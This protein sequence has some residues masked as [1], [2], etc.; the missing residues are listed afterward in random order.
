MVMAKPVGPLCNL[1]CM[2]CY[3]LKTEGS[4]VDHHIRMSDDVLENFIKQYIQTNSGPVVSFTWHGGEPTLAGLDFYRKAVELQKKYLPK[5]WTCWNNLQTNG[6]NLNEEWCAFLAQEHF[7]VGIS[8][9]G[10]QMIH[11]HYR[12]D[13]LGQGSYQRVLDSIHRLKK[14]GILP[15]LLCTVNALTTQD[16]LG[17][18]RTL[19]DLNT[20]WIQ[21]IPILVK[22][23]DGQLS[24][25]SVDPKAYGEF[26]KV[27]FDEWI[28]NDLGV[29]DVQLFAETAMI[30]AGGSASVCW[31]APS[32]G[33]VLVVERNGN[34]YSCDHYVSSEYYL[35]NIETSSLAD[36]VDSK[37]QRQF[38][39]NKADQIAQKCRSCPFLK[40]C[41]GGCPKDRFDHGDQKGLNMLCDGLTAFHEHAQ[42]P[43]KELM[44]LRLQGLTPNQIMDQLRIKFP[45]KT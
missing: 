16:P 33:R 21:F 22:T 11:D 26:L 20:G 40:V 6:I 14:V 28:T 38:G 29:V 31:M 43:L 8:I 17:V 4:K 5:N 35:G 15:D 1:E 10:T 32:C 25:D 42:K 41:N 36:L 30:T 39:Q 9:D 27:I 44:R 18:Y 24:K 23:S 19:R 37:F 45:Y 34:V 7:D 12:K 3:Y 13:G 2:Y